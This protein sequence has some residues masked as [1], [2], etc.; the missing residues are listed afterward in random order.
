MEKRWSH[1][2]WA[3]IFWINFL[4]VWTR[5][6]LTMREEK[7]WTV[8]QALKKQLQSQTVFTLLQKQVMQNILFHF[9]VAEW[10]HV[11][12]RGTEQERNNCAVIMNIAHRKKRFF[13]NSAIHKLQESILCYEKGFTVH[14]PQKQ[15]YFE[16]S[17][18]FFWWNAKR[19]WTW[20]SY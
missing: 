17:R 6:L 3:Y 8:K 10:Q 15:G 1:A 19:P 20:V 9:K 12:N 18:H 13:L 7:S 16:S 11:L 4:T 5:S 2:L 14:I